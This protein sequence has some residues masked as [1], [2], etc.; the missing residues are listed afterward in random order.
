MSVELIGSAKFP[1]EVR[2]LGKPGWY[3]E[4]DVNI[5]S[6]V[7]RET[8]APHVKKLLKDGFDWKKFTP[9]L[10]AV[11]PDRRE[12]LLDGDHRRAM[13]RITFPKKKS[14]SCF[15]IEVESEQEYHR[16][17]AQINWESRKTATKDEVF[18]HKVLAEDAPAVATA[19]SLKRCG[20]SVYGSAD[21]YGTVGCSNAKRV[22]VGSFKKSCKHGELN[23]N[24]AA[25]LLSK[26]WPDDIKIQGELL[27][28]V[29]I[30][31]K[32][33]PRFSD[34]SKI[35]KDFK[36]WFL[37]YVSMR[38]QH[39]AATDYK[40]KGGRIH[41]KHGESLAHGIIMEYRTSKVPGG[42]SVEYKRKVIKLHNTGKLLE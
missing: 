19:L 25:D 22:T 14:M 42:C 8:K 10:I 37:N 41:H 7:N 9:P 4:V 5:K 40:T 38:T 15:R 18:V 31:F 23:V 35:E 3:G 24:M 33:H 12:Y 2:T 36:D 13:F 17:F 28:A 16:L 11:F 21:E 39:I 34:G 1:A 30:L 26:T 32:V 20:L 6:L 27:E 29:T